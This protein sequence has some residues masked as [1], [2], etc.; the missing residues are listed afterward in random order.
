[1]I[2]REAVRSRC[3]PLPLRGSGAVRYRSTGRA[4]L[5]PWLH[6]VAPSGRGEKARSKMIGSETGSRA[7]G[8]AAFGAG[9]ARWQALQLVAAPGAQR[10]CSA[11]RHG[12]RALA[13]Q[14]DRDE[15][16]QGKNQQRPVPAES[17]EGAS[18]TASSR[19]V[20]KTSRFRC[21]R[22]LFRG[23]RLS[24][25]SAPDGLRCTAR[26]TKR[27]GSLLRHAIPR[28]GP[29]T[30]LRGCASPAAPCM[31]GLG[32]VDPPDDGPDRPCDGEPRG[33]RVRR[34][35]IPGCLSVCDDAA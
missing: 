10:C 21:W 9:G 7:A 3:I 12:T 23:H 25:R 15:G 24:N 19:L 18:T 17:L 31:T 5:H 8:L 6:L 22:V 13:Q 28:S 2:E 1:M 30:R 32:V 33:G 16:R 26:G 29:L 11:R 20:R 27:Q 35:P 4:S 14:F 34:V